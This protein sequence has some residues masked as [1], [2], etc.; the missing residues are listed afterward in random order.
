MLHEVSWVSSH[1]VFSAASAGELGE[2]ASSDSTPL[3]SCGSRRD[4]EDSVVVRLHTPACAK[5]DD[6]EDK[7]VAVSQ[8]LRPSAEGDGVD[9][10][11]LV[12]G[13]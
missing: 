9:T 3:I 10:E 13:P 8:S 2:K 4:E 6:M 1:R 11:P 5:G 7:V 12:L